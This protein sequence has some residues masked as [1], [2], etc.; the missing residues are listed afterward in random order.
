MLM[1]RRAAL[2]GL[3]VAAIGF[4]ARAG[5]VTD[6]D[7]IIIGAGVAGISAARALKALGLSAVILEARDRIGGRALT[8]TGT[9]GR[10]FDRGPY[11]LHNKATN[12]LVPLARQ[13]GV[14]LLESSYITSTHRPEKRFDSLPGRCTDHGPLQRL[15][16]LGLRISPERDHQSQKKR[17]KPIHV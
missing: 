17:Y 2:A 11:W 12:P 9:L 6:T 10:A 15:K 16:L 7:V 14:G 4:A 8:E 5:T 13:A 1:D 3:G